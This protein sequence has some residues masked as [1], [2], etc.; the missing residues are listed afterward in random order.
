MKQRLLFGALAIFL[1]TVSLWAQDEKLSLKFDAR[2]DFNY[3]NI[4]NAPDQSGFAGKNLNV[5][6]DGA[7]NSKLEYHVRQR[8]NKPIGENSD[9]LNATD[10]A[11]LTYHFGEGFFVS[12]GK[13]VV[14]I[15][16]FEYDYAPIDCYYL[17]DF[18]NNVAC[19]ELGLTLGYSDRSGRNTLQFQL[20]NSPFVKNTFSGLYSYNLFWSGNFDWFKTLYSVNMIEYE[21]DQFINYIALGNQFSFHRFVLE[22]DFTNR[23]YGKQDNFFDDFSVV[24]Q[25]KYSIGDKWNV[26]VK[27]GYDQNK[28][29]LATTSY[30]NTWDRCVMPGTEFSFYVAGCEFFPLKDRKDLRLHGYVASSNAEPS[31]L[32]VNLGLTWKM[33]VIQR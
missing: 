5:M 24:A 6:L 33:Q 3:L 17:S 20:A 12:A 30:A 2:A 16:G 28:A 15:G 31:T 10:W 8:L 22:F 18:C 11:Y 21:K 14:A 29:Q 13:Q 19:Y 1:S 25:L 9:L 23:F 4:E 27:G 32:F 26:F 7:I